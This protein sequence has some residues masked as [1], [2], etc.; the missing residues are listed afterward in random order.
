VTTNDLEAG[1]AQLKTQQALLTEAVRRIIEGHWTGAEGAAAD[2]VAL[3]GGTA[4]A[5]FA[6]IDCPKG[7]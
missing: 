7:E 3:M 4:P 5:G 6:P 1:Y 2:V